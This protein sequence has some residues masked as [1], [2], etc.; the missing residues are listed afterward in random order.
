MIPT[1]EQLGIGIVPFSPLGTGFLTGMID[2]GTTFNERGRQALAG[3]AIISQALRRAHRGL[4][5]ERRL[6]ETTFRRDSELK[7]GACEG[8]S[9][10]ACSLADASRGA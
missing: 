1:P 10:A 3:R 6:R 9:R 8:R 7:P 2:A 4:S 5:S